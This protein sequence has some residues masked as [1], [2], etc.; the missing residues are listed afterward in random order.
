LAINSKCWLGFG[1][2]LNNKVYSLKSFAMSLNMQ[3]IYLF[4]IAIPVACISWTVTHEE[5]FKEPR[6]FC[7]LNSRRN[8]FFFEGSFSTCLLAN[9]VLVIM[10]Q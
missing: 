8:K 10:L 5:L 9:I 3:L 7:E 4:V 6:K 2:L 1:R